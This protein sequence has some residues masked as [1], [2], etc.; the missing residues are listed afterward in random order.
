MRFQVPQFIEIE[1]K[2]VGNLT[3]K[4]AVYLCGGVGMAFVFYK[5]LPSMLN[6]IIPFGLIILALLLAFYRVNNKPFEDILEAGVKFYINSKL[7]IWKKTEE[8]PTPATKQSEYNN[9]YIPKLSDS[10]LKDLSWSLDVKKID[11]QQKEI[12]DLK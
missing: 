1:D 8:E 11:N 12:R 9:F 3:A 5:I 10:K 2:I 6:I 4:Q 7:Y